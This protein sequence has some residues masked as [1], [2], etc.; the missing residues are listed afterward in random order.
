MF[1]DEMADILGFWDVEL[2]KQVIF[3]AG[4]IQLGMN[5]A[6]G[7][8]FGHLVGGAGFAADLDENAGGHGVTPSVRVACKLTRGKAGRN[9]LQ[10]FGLN[11]TYGLDKATQPRL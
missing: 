1:V 8:F 9:P 3:A 4:G 10:Q 7:D 6:Q 11:A 5:F 2:Q